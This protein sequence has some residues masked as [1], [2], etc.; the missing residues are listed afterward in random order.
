MRY[1]KGTSGNPKGAPQKF[2][3]HAVLALQHAEGK[4]PTT[5]RIRRIEMLDALYKKGKGGD[6]QAIKVYLE[7]AYGMPTAR[8]EQDITGEIRQ[9]PEYTELVKDLAAKTKELE[10][11][12]AKLEPAIRD[13][14]ARRRDVSSPG[15]VRSGGTWNNTGPMADNST[16]ER[17]GHDPQL[18]PANGEE[19]H[20]L[21]PGLPHSKVQAGF[22]DITSQSVPAAILR[23]IQE[24]S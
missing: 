7:R 15:E 9:T 12:K 3:Q 14:D 18:L 4:D 23:V 6:V 20:S 5:K 2:E 21:D 10:N 1:K 19:S 16:G 22:I 17:E 8:V 13:A 11:E 24:G